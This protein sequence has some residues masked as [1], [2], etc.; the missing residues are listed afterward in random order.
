ML[1]AVTTA[2]RSYCLPDVGESI[3]S[4]RT[5][6][7]DGL[8]DVPCPTKGSFVLGSIVYRWIAVR[9]DHLLRRQLQQCLQRNHANAASTKRWLS[10]TLSGCKTEIRDCGVPTPINGKRC[11]ICENSLFSC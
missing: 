11:F 9:G 8:P 7:K 6:L 2:D 4:S 10:N 3:D 1:A 5:I